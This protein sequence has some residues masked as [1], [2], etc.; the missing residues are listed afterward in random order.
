MYVGRIGIFKKA[1]LKLWLLTMFLF[2]MYIHMYICTVWCFRNRNVSPVDVVNML[3]VQKVHPTVCRSYQRRGS[4]FYKIRK[5]FFPDKKL[6]FGPRKK[7][8][9][10]SISSSHDQ[11]CQIVS[12]SQH[13]YQIVNDISND[14]KLYK[15]AIN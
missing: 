12:W 7:N 11:G 14:R 13:T 9:H 1:F 15:T 4:R 10:N 6:F 3:Q 8:C 5:S 2:A